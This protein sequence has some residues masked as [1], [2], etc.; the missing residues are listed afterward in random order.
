MEKTTFVW[1]RRLQHY[2]MI[3]LSDLMS[4][5]LT[6]EPSEWT[7]NQETRISEVDTDN[8]HGEDA[9]EQDQVAEPDPV[10]R[11]PERSA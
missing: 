6:E 4:R 1:Q 10:H 8:A 9:E 5:E 2:A 7:A 11:K 3:L